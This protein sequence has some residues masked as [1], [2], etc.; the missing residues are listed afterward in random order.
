MVPNWA[1]GGAG[2]VTAE[3]LCAETVSA[4]GVVAARELRTPKS[5]PRD[6]RPRWLNISS[7]LHWLEGL[8][9]AL[10]LQQPGQSLELN[11][12]LLA[13]RLQLSLSGGHFATQDGEGD[14]VRPAMTPAKLDHRDVLLDASSAKVPQELV[15]GHGGH[16]TSGACYRS[17][18]GLQAAPPVDD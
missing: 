7:R 1:V 11:T 15:H 12:Y 8:T 13:D 3:S 17:R 18:G 2:N 6:R 16:F 10:L 9:G 4:F 14:I 5:D